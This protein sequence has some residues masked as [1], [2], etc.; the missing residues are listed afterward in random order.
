M[1]ASTKKEGVSDE[2]IYNLGKM[3]VGISWRKRIMVL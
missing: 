3:L 1:M 2:C